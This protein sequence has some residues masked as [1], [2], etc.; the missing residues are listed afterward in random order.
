MKTCICTVIKNEHQYLDEWIQYHLNLGIDHIFI[1]E[2]IDSETHKNITDKYDKVSLFSIDSILNEEARNLVIELKLTKKSNP[3]YTY[4]RKGLLFIQSLQLYDWCFVIDNDEFI[5]LENNDVSLDEL[6]YI[7]DGYDAIILQWKCYGANGYVNRPDYTKKGLIETYT[8]EIKGFVPTATPQSLTKTCYNLRTYKDTF[9]LYTHQPSKVCNF[10]RTNFEK[11]RNKPVYNKIYIRHYITKSWEEY[12]WKKKVRGFLFGSIRDIDFFFKVNPDMLDKKEQLI[13]ELKKE[14]LIVLPYKQK[15]SQGSE[16]ELSLLLWK[17]Y[18]NFDYHFVVIGEFDVSLKEK[19]PWVEFIYSKSIP[20]KEHQY[21]QH[22]DVQNCMEIIA[23][24]YDKIYDGFIWMV[25]DNYAIKFFNLDDIK[26]VHYH[27]LSFTGSSKA[28]TNFWRYDKW[29]TRQ[30]LDKENLPHINYTTHYPCYF[31]FKKLN[32]IWNK[33]NMRNESYVLEDVYFNY[34]EHENPILDSEIRLGIWNHNI[35]KRDFQRALENPNIKFMCNSV[36]GW[37]KDLEESLLNLLNN[38]NEAAEI[39]DDSENIKI[40]ICTVIKDEQEYLDDWL[41]YTFSLGVDKIFI[42]EDEGSASHKEITE[43]Y[44]DKIEYLS[45]QCDEDYLNHGKTR[46]SYHQMKMFEYVC[47]LNVYDWCF[48]MDIDEYITITENIT[49]KKLLSEY[50][51]Y[52]ELILYWKNYGANGHIKKPDYSKVNSYREYYTKTCD[53]SYTDKRYTNIMKKAVNL[54]KI[55]PSKYRV[56]QHYHSM[57]TYIKTNFKQ[58]IHWPCYD[59][60]YLS[61]Y[62]TKSWEEYVWKLLKRGMC[63]KKHR[64]ID[65]FFE[66]NTDMLPMKD[67]LVNSIDKELLEKENPQ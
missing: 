49:L 2:D 1:F 11:D 7:Y 23:K 16:L 18:C 35:Y 51:N 22:L 5:T 47:S 59:R 38:N 42:V 30:L 56:S 63:C 27:S 57:A 60:V 6:I 48:I 10:C 25:D 19:F 44:G 29:K 53:F 17:K 20:K 8:E 21:N 28:P 32:N 54:H 31:E 3:Q 40:C 64:K 4:I 15:G 14:A 45:Y 52:S 34:Y 55:S 50:S 61:H 67:E 13:N 66:M 58:G 36:D 62:I 37:S 65:D 24:K 46:Q 9:F 12:I 41:K 33:F 39:S 26:S 43:K